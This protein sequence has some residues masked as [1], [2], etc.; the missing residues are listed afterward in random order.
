MMTPPLRPPVT[1]SPPPKAETSTK[2]AAK[3][4]PG[5]S[6]LAARMEEAPAA[7]GTS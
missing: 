1:S 6:H 3:P 5:L 4:Y 7:A 2:F